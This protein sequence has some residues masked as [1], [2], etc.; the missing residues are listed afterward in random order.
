MLIVLPNEDTDIRQVQLNLEQF[1]IAKIND[2][3]AQV[4][5]YLQSPS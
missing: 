2:R 1:D 4:K 5:I 3:L